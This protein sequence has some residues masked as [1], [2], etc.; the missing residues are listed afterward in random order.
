MGV[1]FNRDALGVGGD[2]RTGLGF[3]GRT[4]ERRMMV[5]RPAMVGWVSGWPGGAMGLV[6]L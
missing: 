3:M 4:K 1:S 6:K 5:L 2:C